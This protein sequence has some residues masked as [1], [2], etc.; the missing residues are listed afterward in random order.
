MI[1]K[2]SHRGTLLFV[3]PII[4][5]AAYYGFLL[6]MGNAVS[7]IWVESLLMG[8][9]PYL[10][11]WIVSSRLPDKAK[12]CKAGSLIIF[13]LTVLTCIVK[14]F[15]SREAEEAIKMFLIPSFQVVVIW[16]LG[17]ITLIGMTATYMKRK[18][19]GRFT[20]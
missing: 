13:L 15:R 10:F 8:I 5:W 4:V 16:C 1:D 9:A 7:E 3:A 18:S 2:N 6:I 17:L 14:Y 12:L 19:S 11:L 20:H